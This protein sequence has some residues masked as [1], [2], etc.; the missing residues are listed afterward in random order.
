MRTR[1]RF[2]KALTGLKSNDIVKV[3][4]PFGGFVFD[5]ERDKDIVLVAGGIG[6]TPFMSMVRYASTIRAENKIVLIYSCAT[7]DDVP[8]G[9]ELM[10]LE[11]QNPNLR[12]IFLIGDGPTDKLAA[13]HVMSGRVSP[14]VLDVAT[15]GGNYTDKTFFLCGPPPFM[16]AVLG[17]LKTKDVNRSQ[18]MTEAFSQGSRR[19]T[20]QIR[21]WPYNMYISGA[22]G[23]SL[24]GLTVMISDLLRNLPPSTLLDSPSDTSSATL[25]NGRQ[26]DLDSLVNTLP[27]LK[28]NA[29]PS[30]AVTAAL[31]KVAAAE[32]QNSQTPTQTP[33]TATSSPAPAPAPAPQPAPT[34]TTTA[35]GVKIC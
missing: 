26:T 28:N 32:K 15:D 1:G 17:T 29:P 4:G 10:Q 18:I 8:F 35:S 19:Q 16:N 34:C 12:I 30:S 11:H 6:I 9:S 24:G 23:L 33:T 7:Q 14:Q 25:T 3:R 27:A 20:G 22:V 31:A 2:T 5:A 13:K 21:S